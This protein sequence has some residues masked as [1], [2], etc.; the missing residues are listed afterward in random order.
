MKRESRVRTLFVCWLKHTVR[1]LS[2]S[3]FAMS[4]GPQLTHAH[5]SLCLFKE[6]ENVS[7]YAPIIDVPDQKRDVNAGKTSS[8]KRFYKSCQ[9]IHVANKSPTVYELVDVNLLV[10]HTDREEQELFALPAFTDDKTLD[11]DS[12]EIVAQHYGKVSMSPN[13]FVEATVTM[14]MHVH[15]NATLAQE[16][17]RKQ[18][19]FLHSRKRDRGDKRL[20][21][22][23][24]RI[25]TEFS[26]FAQKKAKQASTSQ[27]SS[28]SA[29]VLPR[30]VRVNLLSALVLCYHSWVD[31][32]AGPSPEV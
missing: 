15:N 31:V 13:S 20:K 10:V 2:S 19:P 26:R 21:E 24:G 4:G 6:K 9:D 7:V 23:V 28:V 5:I 17:F 1:I 30:W 27:S 3:Q 18:F 32:A 29:V 11:A 12:L 16:R 25:D 8:V 22:L 14:L